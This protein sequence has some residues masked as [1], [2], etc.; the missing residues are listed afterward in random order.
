MEEQTLELGNLT[1]RFGSE[2]LLDRLH[3]V[4]IPA[5]TDESLSRN[6]SE[7][8]YFFD[9]VKIVDLG[10][11]EGQQ[12]KGI[13]G[14]I[15]KDTKLV[16]EQIYEPGAGLKKSKKTLRTAPSSIFALILNNHRLLY[17][18]EMSDAPGM[19]AFRA[20]LLSFLNQ[21]HKEFVSAEFSK[22]K[23]RERRLPRA[24]RTT[25]AIVQKKFPR[26]TLEIIPLSSGES[27]STFID[28]YEV[29]KSLEFYFS[30][31]NDELDDSEFYEAIQRKQEDL[32]DVRLKFSDKEGLPKGKVKSEVAAA[33]E[34][35]NQRV[36]ISGL[37]HGGDRL[38]G[39]NEDFK[40]KKLVGKLVGSVAVAAKAMFSS[41]KELVEER[42][43]KNP[44]TPPSKRELL[45]QLGD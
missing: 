13:V 21:K 16:R 4:V 19:T 35:G 30:D 8:K 39:N 42:V 37:D 45:D 28:R 25:K 41:Y 33:T 31:R 24:E 23:K 29:I 40:V 14:R 17:I 44:P 22:V 27:I 3:E 11:I 5:F 1:C 26:P 36:T 18:K 38:V 10:R 7:T 15:I 2:V 20:T 43:V 12:Y 9:G 34:G 32:G 6:Y